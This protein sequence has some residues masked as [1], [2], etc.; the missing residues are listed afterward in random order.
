MS[1]TLGL[2]AVLAHPDD[3]SLGTGGILA[4]YSAEGV[5]TSL[6]TATR[7]QS[8]RFLHHRSGPDHP[9]PDKLGVIREAE[10][11]CAA[12]TLGVKDV[13]VLDYIDGALDQVDMREAVGKVAGHIRRV[14]PQV[15]VTFPSDGAY[16]HPDHVA[17]S[18]I[19][20]AAAVAAADPGF[21]VSGATAGHGP[22]AISKLYNIAVPRAEWE[23]YQKVFKKLVSVVDGVE[24][25]AVPW[26]DWAITTVVDTSAHWQR[27]WKAVE[28]HQSQMASYAGM[29]DLSPETHEF[30]WGHQ[31][32]YRV[33]SLVNGG[34]KRETDLF[35]GLRAA[36]PS[37]K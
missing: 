11:R 14:R 1:E 18:Q 17:I 27:V 33:L 24:R 3:E 2:M 7:G 23:I 20:S 13:T 22:H 26:Q 10:L 30:L 16:G 9:G 21:H 34:R 25:E 15:L 28:C 37:T 32:F 36:T 19:T 5:H 29:A 6:I 8:G 31:H 12:E 4:K 35:E